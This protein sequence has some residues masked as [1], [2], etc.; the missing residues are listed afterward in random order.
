MKT[1]DNKTD[2]MGIKQR[3]MIKKETHMRIKQMQYE[4]NGNRLEKG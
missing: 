2:A 1:H 3:R 4:P